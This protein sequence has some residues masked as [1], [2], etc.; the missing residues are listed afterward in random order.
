M[1]AIIGATRQP[2]ITNNLEKDTRA[3]YHEWARY[4]II[5]CV[6]VPLIAQEKLIGFI[7]V[8]RQSEIS[9][10]EVRL[11][12]AVSDIAANAIY[13]STLHE[14]TRKDASELAEA[15]DTTLDGWAR[16]LELREN[17][18]A[19]HSKRVVKYTLELARLYGFHN[20]E[21]IHIQTAAPVC[22]ISA[23]WVFRTGS[24]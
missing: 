15:Y 20:N 24:C 14:Q 5:G 11:L 3:F 16:A 23:K 19:E 13:R 18:T 2:F 21:L 4:G 12:T 17:E 8:G 9:K 10:N 7:W 1:N 22:M 6:G